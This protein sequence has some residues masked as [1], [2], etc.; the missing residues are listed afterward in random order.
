MEQNNFNSN[1]SHPLQLEQKRITVAYYSWVVHLISGN[2]GFHNFCSF[3]KMM[4][5]FGVD[6]PPSIS[7]DIPGKK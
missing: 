7:P 2:Y 1:L 5:E 3:R 6:V 4:F